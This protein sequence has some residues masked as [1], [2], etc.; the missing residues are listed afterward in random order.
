MSDFEQMIRECGEGWVI[1]WGGPG[2]PD[3]PFLQNLLKKVATA[4]GERVGGTAPAISEDVLVRLHKSNPVKAKAFVQAL[5]ATQNPDMLVMTWRILM[6]M[7]IAKVS[8]DYTLSSH[9]S[10]GVVLE[11]PYGELEE[12]HSDNI[13]DAA[14]LRHF[15]IMKMDAK[16]LFDGFYPLNVKGA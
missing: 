13:D 3:I 9:F 10:L 6:G 1:D 5:G 15:G 4:Y 2:A 7:S 16:P 11:S 14:L 8:M 12:Y